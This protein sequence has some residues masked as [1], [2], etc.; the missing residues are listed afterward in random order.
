M[1]AGWLN[2]IMLLV[3]G[4]ARGRSLGSIAFLREDFNVETLLSGLLSLIKD[5]L[6]VHLISGESVQSCKVPVL[7]P[8][9]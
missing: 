2:D 5:V 9:G 4:L 6:S 7:L 3:E 8:G 1:T